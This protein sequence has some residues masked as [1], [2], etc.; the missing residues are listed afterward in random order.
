MASIMSKKSTKPSDTADA[1]PANERQ[2]I[3]GLL[4]G[5]PLFEEIDEIDLETIA[6]LSSLFTTYRGQTLLEEG[7]EGR[8][9]LII[10]SGRVGIHI[11]SIAPY[12]EV[13]I[14]RLGP[15]E[16]IGE[17]A[18]VGGQVRSATAV[19][20]D[21]CEILVVNGEEL[22]RMFDEQPNLAMRMMR[23]VSRILS[24]RLRQMNRRMVNLMRA[25]YY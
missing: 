11:E 8:D 6:D 14:T 24:E 7:E 12:V 3:L 16:V 18:L 25:R 19:A 2:R 22:C 10:V 4:R 5:S 17:M 20:I 1:T 15:G 9:V 23:N 13:G 21:P